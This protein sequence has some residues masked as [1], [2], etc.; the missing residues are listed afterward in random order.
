[1]SDKFFFKGRQ[2]VR[3][4]HIKYGYE[5]KAN[6]LTGSKKY[7]L[8]L[9]VTSEIRKQEVQSLVTEA[10]LYAEITLD[11]SDG[12]VESIAELTALL[13]KNTT[14]K[15]DKTPTRN[16]PCNCGSG[17]KYKKCCG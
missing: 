8:N 1:M 2:D 12:A 4:S 6:R 16:E 3:E 15:I 13:D 11:N 14:V 7:P 5:R 10:Q 17:K 9:L